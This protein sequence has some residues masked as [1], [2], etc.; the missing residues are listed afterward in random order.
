MADQAQDP[1]VADNMA[2]PPLFLHWQTQNA[3]LILEPNLQENSVKI[4]NALVIEDINIH[5]TFKRSVVGAGEGK[6]P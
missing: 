1:P 4:E 2:Y 6:R 5:D 3:R